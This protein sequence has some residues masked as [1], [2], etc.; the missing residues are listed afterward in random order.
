MP[1][2][3]TAAPQLALRPTILPE[4]TVGPLA[5]AT[6]PEAGVTMLTPSTW[7][8]P[9]KLSAEAD[10]VSLTGSTDTTYSA[11]AFMLVGDARKLAQSK[12]TFEFR[13][14]ISDPVQQLD[15]L[16][17]AINIDAPNWTTAQAYTG[18]KYPAAVSIGF[19]R[20]NQLSIVLINA[21]NNRWIYVGTQAP[22]RN[23]TYYNSA[24][25]NPAID[26]ITLVTP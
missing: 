24:I 19:A 13:D 7:Q 17:A 16:L 12:L 14:D 21:G 25:F 26:S 5:S 20:D 23:Y 8:A 3:P 2:P 9:V 6:L 18:A 15:L 22:E 4:S 11:G 10:V 1:V